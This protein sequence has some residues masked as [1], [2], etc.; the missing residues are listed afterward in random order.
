M[1]TA[2]RGAGKPIDFG[3]YGTTGVVP[4]GV[5]WLLETAALNREGLWRHSSELWA[6]GVLCPR[7][8]TSD[9]TVDKRIATISQHYPA[10]GKTKFLGVAVHERKLRGQGTNYLF[11][12]D[13]LMGDCVNIAEMWAD[14]YMKPAMGW[15]VRK[16][17]LCWSGLAPGSV[18]V[19]YIDLD[20]RAP[21]GCFSNVWRDRVVPTVSAINAAI[22]K[23]GVKVDRTPV[24]MNIRDITDK[25]GLAKYSFHV[26][27][28]SFGIR[29]IGTWKTFLAS[30][31]DLPRALDWKQDEGKWHS[32][33]N[34]SP[35]VDMAV[36]G[37][38]SQ[39][40]RGPFCG[41]RGDS[42]AVMY[43][44]IVTPGGGNEYCFEYHNETTGCDRVKM[45]NHILDARITAYPTDVK[46]L[47][48][49]D[50]II[51]PVSST[52]PRVAS[53][54]SRECTEP[55]IAPMDPTVDNIHRFI[56]PFLERFILPEW[57][58][59]RH[60]MLMNAG[61][62]AGAVV[63]TANLVI[64]HERKAERRG[65][66]FF[67]VE[68]DTF[69]ECDPHHIHTAN[70]GKIGLV[71]DYVR[72]TIAQTCFVCGPSMRF[73]V[74]SFLH[75][76]NQIRMVP[77][78]RCGHSRISCWGKSSSP[79]QTFLDFYG[80]R[81]C[82]QGETQLVHVYDEE[83]RVWCS[84][85]TGNAIA[86]RL[87]D[88]LNRVHSEYLDAQRRVFMD[89][90][91]ARLDG[92]E[93]G[94]DEGD[95]EELELDYDDD[96]DGGSK[97]DKKTP[98]TREEAVRDIERKARVFISKRFPFVTFPPASRAKFLTDLAGCN[99]HVQVLQMNPFSNLI[100]MV[101]G[102]CIDVFT[103]VIMDME[104][105]HYFTSVVNAKF[106]PEDPNIPV[107][108][109]WV[110]EIS[111][112]DPEKAT[113]L[114]RIGAYCMTMLIHDRKLYVFVGNG[115]NGKGM[116]KE[117]IVII[118]KGPDGY[119][120]RVKILNANFW[121]AR[122]NSGSS[123]ESA[124]PEAWAMRNASLLYTD[125]IGPVRLDS[126]K[127]KRVVGGE[128]QAA[129]GLYGDSC[130]IKPRGK[131]MYTSNFDPN[132]PGDDQAF[133][134]RAVVIRMNTKYVEDESQVNPAKFRFRRDFAKAAHLLTMTDAFFTVCVTELIR[135]YKSVTQNGA[136]LL[137][138]FPIPDDIRATTL[139]A[140]EKRM[141][142]AAFVRMHLEDTVHPLQYVKLEDA[143]QNYLRYLENCNETAVA[144]ITTVTSFAELLA[145]A[146]GIETK[147]V[148]G[149]TYIEGKRLSSQV[150]EQPQT[151]HHQY[152][153]FV[154]P[155]TDREF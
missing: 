90:A 87:I 101:G 19:P 20:E 92:D 82:I 68:G 59:F 58:A 62:V 15:E 7:T 100:P 111:T 44:V 154:D 137:V 110:L 109:N 107:I 69:C 6:H 96:D 83:K 130:D 57:Q 56:K 145:M 139:A 140:K 113:Y 9:K 60:H 81:V 45:V 133:W 128:E 10:N 141:P 70:P 119:E 73:P 72:S 75:T 52:M 24:F 18:F 108:D 120:K 115:G 91:I 4:F 97:K 84:G 155:P 131:V 28:P 65:R 150:T 43:P 136:P 54:R 36:Y 121:S 47:D 129:R 112:S 11:R 86:G 27:W 114:K 31:E 151:R 138:S 39:L 88:K 143:F 104:R 76:G 32:E 118:S 5:E 89:I 134:E 135:Y 71:L 66:A 21:I 51:R 3:T 116:F 77:R 26:H 79:Y 29:S 123:A 25:P 67:S 85:R 102:Q 132:G 13:H 126:Q 16:E 48:I 124:T 125:E 50:C 34:N 78:D 152:T 117:F 63:P 2:A 144:K 22:T 80:D 33:P 127:V 146:L 98:K 95:D 142:L 46:I 61:G 12:G 30:L 55:S 103:G 105:H 49:P 23:L 35:I 64:N 37:G 17:A 147:T 42:S 106:N 53:V 74:Y 8:E 93:E 149:R 153:G 99:V 148:S 38:Q 122:A 14:L 1:T 40:F 41:K 94:G